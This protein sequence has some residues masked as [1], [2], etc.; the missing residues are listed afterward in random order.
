M[1]KIMDFAKFI[2]RPNATK[3]SEI[4]SFE[5]WM[6]LWVIIDFFIFSDKLILI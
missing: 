2:C 3:I 1:D 6:D 5:F 4:F